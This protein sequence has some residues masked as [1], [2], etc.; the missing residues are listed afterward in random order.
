[1][2]DLIFGPAHMID[3]GQLTN[4]VITPQRVQGYSAATPVP[5]GNFNDYYV[6]YSSVQDL[7][8][9]DRALLSGHLLSGSA[10]RALFTSSVSGDNVVSRYNGS[11]ATQLTGCYECYLRKAARTT[12]TVVDNPGT[13]RGFGA[14]DA[15]S[16]DDGTIAIMT[17]NDESGPDP[18]NVLF[19]LAA[20]L[21]WHRQV[22]ARSPS[23]DSGTRIAAYLTRARFNGYVYLERH[24]HV[25]LSKGFGM[26]DT[27]DKLPNTLQTKWPAFAETR[28][29]VGVAIMKLQEQKKLSVQDRI[30]KYVRG[31]PAS[32]RAI[33]VR[34]L[35]TNTSG[36]ASFDPFLPGV[37][38]GR[39]MAGCKANPLVSAPGTL[40][41][42]WSDCNTFLLGVILERVT[43]K[44]W[45]DAMQELI[46]SPMGM[47]NSGRMTNALKPP[48]R[49]RL[50]RAGS[51]TPELNYE[52]YNLAY[53]TAEDM[54]RLNHALLA[55]TL[56]SRHSLDTM[57]TPLFYDS[58]GDPTSPKRGY[59]VV[60][61][62][63][64]RMNYR[65]ACES[66]VSGGGEDDEG[67][68]AGF[69]MSVS[70]SLG[71]GTLQVEINNDSAYFNWGENENAFARFIGKQLYGK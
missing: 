40:P 27:E 39:T 26:A 24:G 14:D 25:I 3:S 48:Q 21:L 29:L 6:A 13:F 43:G 46:F 41:S 31:C 68:H 11:N 5:L 28:F 32:W 62:P 64:T 7:E 18:A 10:L 1:M 34:E 66:C 4:S 47:A 49:G 65:V 19:G 16:P 54:I 23:S 12:V 58:P 20:H 37:T 51:P 55:G 44:I 42:G 67:A 33:T 52:G 69:F 63:D 60:M 61:S 38:L 59:E 45:A 9:M 30:C 36:M 22:S 57:F 71:T 15:L 70:L 50:Y 2:Q 53:T 8:R 17:K 35:L 56:I